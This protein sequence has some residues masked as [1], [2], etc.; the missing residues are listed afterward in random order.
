MSM[1]TRKNRKIVTLKNKLQSISRTVS[2][3]SV[4]ATARILELTLECNQLFLMVFL[5]NTHGR[6]WY[7][8]IWYFRKLALILIYCN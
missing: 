3:G 8:I 4:S 6:F 2:G 5:S 7:A 1:S